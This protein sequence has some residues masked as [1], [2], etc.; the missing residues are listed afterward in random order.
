MKRTL[1]TAVVS[2]AL[3]LATLPALAMTGIQPIPN[4]AGDQPQ[5][6]LTSGGCGPFAHRTPFGFCR[7]NFV[8]GPYG[9][10]GPRFGYGY[11]RHFFFHRRFY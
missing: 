3:T 8:G 5:V 9:F 11:H 10:Y 1:L 6:I 2:G 4:A 7:R